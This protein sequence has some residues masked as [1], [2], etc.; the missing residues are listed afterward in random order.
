[1]AQNYFNQQGHYLI[2]S[3]TQAATLTDSYAGNIK[4]MAVGGMTQLELYV[5]YTPGENDA[6]LNIQIE[7]GPKEDDLYKTVIQDIEASTGIVTILPKVEK[8]VG[9][10]DGTTYKFR[11]SEP[12]A[13]KVLRV[14]AKETASIHG[15]VAIRSLISGL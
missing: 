1:M 15:T 4:T 7:F 3:E 12:I 11:I 6:V 10:V 8:F 9:S 5:A 2:G 13:D 14:S